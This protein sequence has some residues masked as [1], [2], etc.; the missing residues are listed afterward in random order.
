MKEKQWEQV[1]EAMKAHGGYATFGQ[2][3]QLVDTSTWNTKTPAA[4]I[5][6]IVQKNDLFF[7]VRPG[8][9]GLKEYEKA[10][11]SKFQFRG[12]DKKKEELFTHSYYQGL[13]IEIGR[14]KG[15]L[16]YVPPQD[17]NRLFIDRP[18]KEMVS[19]EAIPPNFAYPEILRRAKTVD[20]IWFNE[21]RMPSSF[22]EVEHSTDIQNSLTKFFEL[23]DYYADFSIVAQESRKGQFD[24]VMSKSIFKPIRSRVTFVSYENIGKQYENMV[25]LSHLEQLI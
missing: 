7:R 25:E 16:T 14:M 6:R 15:M 5:R 2:L 19:L 24:D 18:L 9:W 4:S 21:R 10:V 1:V 12:K 20:V 11:L 17:K 3:N 8:L 13:L 22:F 23:Q